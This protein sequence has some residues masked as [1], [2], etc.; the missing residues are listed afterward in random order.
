M[1]KNTI[2]RRYELLKGSTRLPK[3]TLDRDLPSLID[4]LKRLCCDVHPLR[5]HSLPLQHP[6]YKLT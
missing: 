2:K 1:K 5:V 4:Q 6:F 3:L